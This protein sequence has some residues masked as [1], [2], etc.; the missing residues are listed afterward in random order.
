MES[1]SI[2]TKDKL[3]E[4]LKSYNLYLHKEKGQ[5]FLVDDGLLEKEVKEAEISQD[6]I[7]LEI[8]AGIGT[9][10]KKIAEKAGKVYAVEN[11]RDLVFAL[12]QE[13]NDFENV[14]IIDQDI[15]ETELPEFDKSVSNIPYYLSSEIIEL[16]GEKG[17]LSVITLQR[18]FAERLVA[19]P[20]SS[21]YSRISVMANYFFLPVMLQ[22]VSRESFFPR[23]EVDSALV[24]LFPREKK[25]GIEDRDFF[26]KVVKALF[27]HKNK[28][29]RTSFYDSRHFFDLSKEEA[30]ELRDELPESE[31]R[32]INLNLKKMAEISKFLKK[33]LEQ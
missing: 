33:R 8:G 28:K 14:E 25:F 3:K 15:L 22:E 21:D 23:P 5:S 2:V 18:E 16:L 19:K 1:D 17:N 31:E 32:T 26:F 27:I 30:K 9:L 24:K 13:L 10:T 29:V 12:K 7:V 6:D 20:G 4:L 11:D